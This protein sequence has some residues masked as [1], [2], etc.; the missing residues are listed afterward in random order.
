M[1]SSHFLCTHFV[2]VE[3]IN[4]AVP[5]ADRDSQLWYIYT[6]AHHNKYI[7]VFIYKP[8]FFC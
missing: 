4:V 6:Y 5:C 8:A 2:A 7:I 1:A 3:V